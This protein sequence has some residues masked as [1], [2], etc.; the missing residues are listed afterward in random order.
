[1]S[2]LVDLGGVSYPCSIGFERETVSVSVSAV[3]REDAALGG[4]AAQSGVYVDGAGVPRVLLPSIPLPFSTPL[5]DLFDTSLSLFFGGL[6]K[7]T[8]DCLSD[9]GN[10]ILTVD[11]R[12]CFL[13]RFVGHNG[14]CQA[15]DIVDMV[16]SQ[17]RKQTCTALL[18]K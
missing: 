15:Q 12:S 5:C 16:W 2:A 3:S 14:I 18:D 7:V 10:N 11:L 8:S 1:M 4:I 6:G 13:N 9:A 17:I